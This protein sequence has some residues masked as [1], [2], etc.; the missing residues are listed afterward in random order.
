MKTIGT[1]LKVDAL[2]RCLIPK[3]ARELYHIT[4]NCTVEVLTTAEGILIR[5]PQYE[6]REIPVA[7]KK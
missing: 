7:E 4:K 6:V 2:G 5:N 3:A 1:M